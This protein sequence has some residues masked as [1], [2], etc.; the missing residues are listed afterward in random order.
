MKEIKR[1]KSISELHKFLECPAPK[2]P[3]ISLIEKAEMRISSE[4]YGRK[5]V[6][7]FYFITLRENCGAIQYGRN[8]YDFEEGTLGFFSPGQVITPILKDESNRSEVGWSLYFH[9]DFLMNSSLGYKMRDYTFFSYTA[10]EAL[11][12]S[13]GEKET[14]YD[15]VQKIK[16]EYNQNIDKHSQGLMISNLELLLNYC[17]RFYDR[18]FYTR[19]NHHQDVVTKTESFLLQYFNSEK[20]LNFGLPTVKQC[21][22][23]VNL[24]PNYLS[25]LLKKE[26]GKN[27]KEH[28]DYYLL[29]RA[30]SLLLTTNNSISEI[31]YEL[32]FEYS[33]SFS[34]S[35]KKGIGIT[36]N[37]F[38]RLN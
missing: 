14:L 37:E 24:S 15:C 36:P 4:V 7:D 27:T 3:A 33:Q 20:S 11:H 8:Y 31:A 13:E 1:I 18:Q 35:F 29:E 25:D 19:S 30:K 6:L 17:T 23:H 9:P 26:T 34:K 21:A 12:I 10:N 2:H 32:G 38:R 22:E 28:I 5:H 16:L